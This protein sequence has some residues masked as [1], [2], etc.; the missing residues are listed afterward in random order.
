MID[1][2]SHHFYSYGQLATDSCWLG[3][4]PST[5]TQHGDTIYI[6]V[7]FQ[8]H[9]HTHTLKS[10]HLKTGLHKRLFHKRHVWWSITGHFSVLFSNSLFVA[11]PVIWHL[12][13]EAGS[14][15]VPLLS[16]SEPHRKSDSSLQRETKTPSF[17][18]HNLELF[19]S[20]CFLFLF[21]PIMPSKMSPL[22]VLIRG[23]GF[24]K[25]S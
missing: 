10:H 9:A 5:E 2:T 16:Q 20:L 25:M 7:L 4:T 3:A 1:Y 21:L 19:K 6:R 17:I 14:L 12:H 11:K 22:Y 13:T 23:A 18:F 8:P 24:I 15:C